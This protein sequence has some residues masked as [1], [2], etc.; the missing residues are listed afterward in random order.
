MFGELRRQELLTAAMVLS[1]DYKF[2]MQPESMKAISR[3]DFRFYYFLDDSRGV[4]VIRSGLLKRV[5]GPR[6]RQVKRYCSAGSWN[7]MI[8]SPAGVIVLLN[9]CMPRKHFL[10]VRA[11]VT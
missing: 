7:R 9:V 11:V 6:G 8:V 2:I 5:F 10:R 4:D 3:S 1:I